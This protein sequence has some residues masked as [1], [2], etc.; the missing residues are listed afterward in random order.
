MSAPMTPPGD[1]A[2]PIEQP[3]LVRRFSLL[4][5]TA[6]NMTNMLG[7]GPF[8]TIPL[9]M[10]ALGGP[11]A[12]L[13][14]IVALVI[15]I[16]DGMIWSELGAAMPGSGG[17]FQYLR[18]AFGRERYGR[19]MAFLFVWQF[20]LS[21][22]LEIAS[23]YIGFAQY[24]SYIWKDLT[25]P[26][27]IALV[28]VVG[29][30]NIAL[31][32]RRI[33]SIAKITVSLWVG[34]LITVFAVMVTGAAHF[35]ADIAFDFPPG[36]FNFS[37]GFFLGL[38]AASRIGIYDYL[39]YY[40][41]CYIGD[42]VRDP[43]RVIPRSIL[44]S[45][46]AVAIIYIGINL[47][48]IGVVPWREFVPASAHPE[49]NFIVSTFM[50]KVYG[51]PVATF[52]TLMILWTAFGSVFALLLGY[53]RIPFAAAQSGYFFRAFGRL[54]PTKG[55]PYVSLLVLGAISIVAG[56]F[57]LGTVIDALI[58]TRILVQFMGQTFGL[59]LLR[60]HAPD[61]PRPYRMWL[62]P[63]PALVA[64]LGWIFVFATTQY[65]VIL[66]GVGV[67]ALGGVAFLLWSRTT[68]RWP[69]GAAARADF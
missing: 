45:T 17:S 44:I 5:A 9:L 39:G 59:M 6:L 52:F 8:I 23:G 19:L 34:T 55:F 48:I 4:P 33:D 32:Y 68:R 31:L 3:H 41:V 67:L 13:G 57:S 27:V 25:R 42:E 2:T 18:E 51:G 29:L 24:A 16:C 26:G 46:V 62:Y 49:S 12:M 58:V 50:E 43:G 28:T 40:D 14:W 69:F 7:A 63:L 56:F 53:S 37:L 20:V 36:A 30:I 35:D 66:F 22:P 54:H 60:R 11:Q 10:T 65:R 15:V 47:S 38:G 61:M 21:G 64:L 1:T